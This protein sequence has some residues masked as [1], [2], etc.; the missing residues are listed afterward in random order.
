MALKPTRDDLQ[1]QDLSASAA[2]LESQIEE[3]ERDAREDD[4]TGGAWG[5]YKNA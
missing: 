2:D 5:D 1:E 3:Q 4:W